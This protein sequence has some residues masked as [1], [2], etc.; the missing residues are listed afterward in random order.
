MGGSV[1]LIDGHIDYMLKPCPFC[2]FTMVLLY[3]D[4]RVV[5]G[6]CSATIKRWTDDE[7]V[8]AWNRR[9]NA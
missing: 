8:D 9:V 5:C 7:A 1:S 4:H 2:G 3:N 6:N